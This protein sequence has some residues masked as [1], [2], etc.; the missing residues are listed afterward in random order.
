MNITLNNKP[1]N[2]EGLDQV[3]V[4]ELMKLKNFTYKLLI[5]RINNKNVPDEER[6]TTFIKD[7]DNVMILHLITGG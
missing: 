4:T 5:V 6:D 2:I 3:S 1:E 7:G